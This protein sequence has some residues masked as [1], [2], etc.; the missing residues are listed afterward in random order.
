MKMIYGYGWF[1][2]C[3]FG[4]ASI[5]DIC[6]FSEKYYDIHDYPIHKGGDGHPQHFYVYTCHNCGEVFQI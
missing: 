6:E 3:I 4:W 2:K 1:L 5:P